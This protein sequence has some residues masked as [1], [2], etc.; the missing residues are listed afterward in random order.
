MTISIKYFNNKLDI[1]NVS[2]IEQKKIRCLWDIVREDYADWVANVRLKEFGLGKA[3]V[4]LLEWR[5]MSSWWLTPLVSKTVGINHRWMNRLMVL[6]LCQKYLDE[7]VI[8]TDDKLLVS[9]VK[10]NFKNTN[11]ALLNSKQRSIKALIK[12]RCKR[13]VNIYRYIV[14]FMQQLE[15]WLVLFSL[16]KKEKCKYDDSQKKIWFHTLYP[17][18][19]VKNN[20]V[21]QD[22][23]LVDAPLQDLEHNKNSHYLVYV[24][25]Y[26]KDNNFS[27]HQLWKGVREL[28]KKSN[29]KVDFP[30][31]HLKIMDIISV[32]FSTQLEYL[33]LIKWQRLSKFRDLFKINGMDVSDILISEWRTGYLGNI[34]YC[35]LHGL[36]TMRFLET[37]PYRPIIINY[38]EFYIET[39]ADYHLRSLTNHGALYYALQ[40]TQLSRN[41]GEA[42]N[43]QSEFSQN[44]DLD[45]IFYC[46]APDYFL[47]HGKQY[48]DILSEFYPSKK[49]KIIGSLKSEQYIHNINRYNEE[50]KK[51]LFNKI[52]ISYDKPSIL[53]AASSEDTEYIC[54]ILSKWHPN[55]NVNIIFTPHPSSNEADVEIMIKKYLD[56]LPI[57]FICTISTAKIM[58][59]MELVI[60]GFSNIAYES[61]L[62]GVSS[63]MLLPLG[64]FF[65][66]EGDWRIP[67]FFDGESFNIWFNEH[68]WIN[69]N[70]KEIYQ[71]MKIASEYYSYPDLNAT[72]G[73]WE[74]ISKEG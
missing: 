65:P 17:A 55:I 61:S 1:E 69:N 47:A 9:S 35:K 50:T 33:K 26:G 10:K 48:A 11:I 52:G 27:F 64:A 45:A 8:K 16:A 32:Y 5:G 38:A 68:E 3:L 31:A 20:A 39:R 13:L 70:K 71:L 37:L 58:T 28:E 66:R 72:E 22:R 53:I 30:Q 7:L 56:H 44:N 18:N 36:A 25:R 57:K 67:Q 62:Y 21:W 15:R 43:R 34:Q 41:T 19:W 54:K 42:Y 29:R 12:Y 2:T 60:C 40:H 51:K 23:V 49:I 4:E 74:A 63:V 6:Y 24:L 73:M 14:S 59:Y 46:P